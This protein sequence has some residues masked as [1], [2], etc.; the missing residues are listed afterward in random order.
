MNL[1]QFNFNH[2]TGWGGLILFSIAVSFIFFSLVYMMEGQGWLSAYDEESNELYLDIGWNWIRGSGVAFL[3]T[4]LLGGLGIFLL[5]KN[6]KSSEKAGA[7]F[8][9]LDLNQKKGALAVV[10]ISV[11]FTFFFN[12]AL[13]WWEAEKWFV[14]GLYPGNTWF[15]EEASAWVSSATA[16]TFIGIALEAV[17]LVLLVKTWRRKT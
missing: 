17:A 9:K 3:T 10:L 16:M 6:K 5:R 7:L 12:A 14:G 11:G 15:F 1:S 8:G 4:L 2:K 13:Y